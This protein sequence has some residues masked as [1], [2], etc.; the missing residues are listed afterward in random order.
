VPPRPGHLR[1][2]ESDELR[3]RLLSIQACRGGSEDTER[4]VRLLRWLAERET[5]YEPPPGSGADEMSRVTS[6]EVAQHLGL[7]DADQFALQRL[8]MGSDQGGNRL[9]QA[10]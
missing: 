4:F 5:A 10:Q 9:M 7:G 1:P 3:L 6:T 8:L 2:I